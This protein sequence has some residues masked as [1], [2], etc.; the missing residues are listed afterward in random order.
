VDRVAA[1]EVERVVE[2][3]ELGVPLAVDPALDAEVTDGGAGDRGPTA[4]GLAVAG[5]DVQRDDPCPVTDDVEQLPGQ[6]DL[7]PGRRPPSQLG[8]DG[9][10]ERGERPRADHAV[11]REAVDALERHDRGDGL[12]AP[13]PVRGPSR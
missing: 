8:R 13:H 12:L 11:D 3:A 6:V 7:D 4:V 2:D 10:V 9:S 1:V 5:A